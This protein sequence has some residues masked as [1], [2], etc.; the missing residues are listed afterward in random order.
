MP[1]EEKVPITIQIT[2]ETREI[3]TRV[4]CSL[5]Y[6]EEDRLPY[7]RIVTAM[8]KWFEDNDEWEDIA[9]EIRADIGREAQER[10]VRDRERKRKS[11]KLITE[12]VGR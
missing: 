7:G 6:G 8:T 10:S 3:L 12:G 9:D 5:V 2:A 4:A 1:S 11:T